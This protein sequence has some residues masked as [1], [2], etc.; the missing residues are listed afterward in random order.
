MRAESLT[1]QKDDPGSGEARKPGVV[2]EPTNFYECRPMHRISGE[3]DVNALAFA[4]LELRNAGCRN[5]KFETPVRF[6]DGL[7]FRFSF[8]KDFTQGVNRHENSHGF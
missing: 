7:D 1:G 5:R 2:F 6:A 4:H 8:E 3:G